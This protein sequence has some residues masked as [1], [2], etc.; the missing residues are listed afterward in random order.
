M[1]E[2]L[3][4]ETV[5]QIVQCVRAAVAEDQ[6]LEVRGR[7]SKRR[8][9]RPTNTGTCLD[10]SKFTGITL[11]EPNEL[12]LMAKAATPIAEIEA[13]LAK[14]RQHLAFEPP[15][16]GAVLGEGAGE[17]SIGGVL[18]CNLAG[19]RR[20]KSGAARDHILGFNAVS[21][22]GEM[23]KSGGR[24]M[25]NVTGF[26]LSKL[27]AG[28]MG[29]LAA[30]TDVTVKVLPAPEKT[31]TVLVTGLADATAVRAMTDALNSPFEVSGA[32]HMP[33]AVAAGS[34]VS[35]VAGAGAADTAIRIEGPGPSVE[36]RCA[37]LRTLLGAF[38]AVEELHSKNSF[39]LWREI[40]DA[41]LV[42]GHGEE[43]IWR[44]SVPP[45]SGPR[46]VSEIVRAAGGRYFYD[47]GGG[48][49]WIALP[50]VADA[51]HT[52]VRAAIG[53]GGGHASLLRAAESVRAAV[54]VFQ[55][56][57]DALAQLTQRVKASF[58][59]KGILNRGRMYAGV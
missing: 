19:P 47:W 53:A 34:R 16:L 37:S 59:P 25:K 26:D 56:Q 55:P 1:A 21:G 35:Y 42:A 2:H 29:T 6:A 3:R 32:A 51:A 52:A 40:R 17:G 46:V 31:R 41:T 20:I 43:Q 8:L 11:Y 49:I 33:V 57:A 22:R 48:L 28:S 9:G 45:A 23:F 24:V 30:L 12:V 14:E 58:D 15:D 27:M 13:V 7:G 38:G 5:E 36:S 18:A 4:P 44:L 50:P 54:P 10:L 39:A